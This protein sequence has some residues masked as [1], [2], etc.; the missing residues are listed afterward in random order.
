LSASDPALKKTIVRI[1]VEHKAD[2]DAA[3]GNGQVVEIAVPTTLG[4]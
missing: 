1:R 4:Q 2:A 3:K